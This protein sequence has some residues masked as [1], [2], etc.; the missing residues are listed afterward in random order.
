MARR[1]RWVARGAACG[2]R[3]AAPCRWSAQWAAQR[4]VLRRATTPPCSPAG[5]AEGQLPFE[6]AGGEDEL[7]LPLR[8]PA[9]VGMGM[10]LDRGTLTLMRTT[11][12]GAAAAAGF[13]CAVGRRVAA[14]D[15]HAVG[16]ADLQQLRVAEVGEVRFAAPDPAL[17]RLQGWWHVQPGG[18][19]VR[20]VAPFAEYWAAGGAKRWDLLIWTAGGSVALSRVLP[21]RYGAAGETQPSLAAAAVALGFRLGDGAG[22]MEVEE[23]DGAACCA[24]VLPGMR[25]LGANGVAISSAAEA[26]AAL[27]AAGTAGCELCFGALLDTAAAAG[28]GAAGAGGAD[29][30]RS[31]SGA[32][33]GDDGR[34]EWPDC[35]VWTRAGGPG[36]P[37]RAFI[38]RWQRP[39]RGGQ[40]AAAR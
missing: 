22:G 12:G 18:D 39:R 31:G 9:G 33:G 3:P 37:H 1:G 38:E 6:E 4:I 36:C 29:T 11:P 35:S 26:D 16:F 20:V 24:G 14:V 23:A 25:L 5:R 27:R 34:V 19:A 15:G 21:L 40:A 13:D 28:C 10:T 7:L 17:L 8:K 30:S 2:A 32:A